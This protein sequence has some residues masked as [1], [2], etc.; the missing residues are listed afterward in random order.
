M[1]AMGLSMALDRASAEALL[2]QVVWVAA[3]CVDPKCSDD[4]NKHPYACSH[5]QKKQHN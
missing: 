3:V 2:P 4:H 5:P 1:D